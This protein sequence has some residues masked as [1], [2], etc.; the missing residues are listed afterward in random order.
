MGVYNQTQPVI[1]GCGNNQTR[2][3][4]RYFAYCEYYGLNLVRIGAADHWGTG[5]QYDAWLNHTSQYYAM[6]DTMCDRAYAHNVKVV[7]VI[8]GSASNSSIYSFNTPSGN[9]FV[10]SSQ[11]YNSYVQ[12][13]IGTMSHLNAMGVFEGTNPYRRQRSSNVRT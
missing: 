9:P 3:W 7:L 10:I 4:D 5:F 8:A 12:Y 13:A 2:F 6:L 1:Q 11:A